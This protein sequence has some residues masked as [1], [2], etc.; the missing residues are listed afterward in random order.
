MNYAIIL[1]GGIS[2]RMG[3]TDTPKQFIFLNG[4]PLIVYSLESAQ[5]NLNI[6]QLCVVCSSEWSGAVKKWAKQ[7]NI[8]KL[9]TIANAGLVRQE[10]VHK[11]IKSL[12]AKKDDIV[13]IMTAVCP[14][15]T[16]KTID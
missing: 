16:Q 1:A 8:T 10:T 12:D 11:G 6:D 4:K 3:N 7:Y 13:M 15:V 5:K 14:F 2:V 9:V